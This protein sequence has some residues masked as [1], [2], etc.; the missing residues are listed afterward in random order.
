MVF[1]DCLVKAHEL[2]AKSARNPRVILDPCFSNQNGVGLEMSA[3]RLMRD[4][5]GFLFVSYL[6]A[7]FEPK[8]A[9]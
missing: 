9:L 2:E 8:L 3:F 7:L 1:G 4:V 6:S 5:D